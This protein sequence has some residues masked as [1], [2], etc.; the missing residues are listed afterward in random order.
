MADAEVRFT[1]GLALGRRINEFNCIADAL[2]GLGEIALR[3]GEPGPARSLVEESLALRRRVDHPLGVAAALG[4]LGRIALRQQRLPDA[5]ALLAESLAICR[6]V[7]DRV[8]LAEVVEALVALH[9]ASGDLAR[10]ARLAG[11]AEAVREEIGAPLTPRARADLGGVLAQLQAVLG[12]DAFAAARAEGRA[13]NRLPPADV[14]VPALESKS[15]DRSGRRGGPAPGWPGAPARRV[16]LPAASQRAGWSLP[17]PPAGP[18]FA[19]GRRR[20]CGPSWC[21]RRARRPPVRVSGPES[22]V[23]ADGPAA[24][25]PVTPRMTPIVTSPTALTPASPAV[26]TPRRPHRS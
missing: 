16:R 9:A 4:S 19:P 17:S 11:T 15:L 26:L 6:A 2:A 12:A 8:G 25:V 23:P 7:G 22:R 14:R 20:G 5:A 13:A 24:T 10:A 21:E 1:E 18:P 3:R